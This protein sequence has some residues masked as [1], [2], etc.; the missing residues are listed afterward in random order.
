MPCRIVGRE[1]GRFACSRPLWRD[2][3]CSP[4]WRLVALPAGQRGLT[5]WAE[6][7][8]DFADLEYLVRAWWAIEAALRMA[9]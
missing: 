9:A 6:S 4:C 5:D 8:E 2:G 7:A 1:C 3:L